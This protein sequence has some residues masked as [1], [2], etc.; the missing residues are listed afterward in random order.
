MLILQGRSKVSSVS[1]LSAF[2]NDKSVWQHVFPGFM[3]VSVD[4]K[5]FR[6]R[7]VKVRDSIQSWIKENRSLLDALFM[8]AVVAVLVLLEM[9][10]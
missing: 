2:T 7:V 1:N 4:Q 6:S 5:Q 10:K 8:I 9:G 3:L